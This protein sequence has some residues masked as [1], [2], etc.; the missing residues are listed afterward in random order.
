MQTV[1][2]KKTSLKEVVS[3]DFYDITTIENILQEKEQYTYKDYA[4]LPEGAP[5]QLIRGELIMTPSPTPYHQEISRKLEFK[6]QSFLENKELGQLYHAPLDVLLGEKDVYQPD[7]Y[8]S[9]MRLRKKLKI[10]ILI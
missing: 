4:K 5:Y 7:I 1:K 10:L 8:P 9:A 3:P 2:P 6:I